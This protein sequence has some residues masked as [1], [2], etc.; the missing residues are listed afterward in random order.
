[1]SHLPPALRLPL[2]AIFPYLTKLANKVADQS[3]SIFADF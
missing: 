1:M 2:Q 3:M